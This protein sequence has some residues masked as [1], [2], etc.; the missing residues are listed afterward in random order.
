MCKIV[1]M[2]SYGV[3]GRQAELASLEKHHDC[4][5]R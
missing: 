2:L 4:K 3:S 1:L 5:G